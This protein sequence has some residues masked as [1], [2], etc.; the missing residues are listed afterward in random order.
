MKV[1]LDTNVL[2]DCLRRRKLETIRLM[3]IFRD[4]KIECKTSIFTMMELIDTEKDH[5]FFENN[6]KKGKEVSKILR[7]RNNRNLN[8]EDLEHIGEG[9]D[10]LM[11]TYGFIEFVTLI[12]QGGNNSFAICKESNLDADDSI[13]LASALGSGCTILLTSDG[14]FKKE[15]ERL[16]EKINNRPEKEKKVDFV[17]MS[18][19][20]FMKTHKDFVKK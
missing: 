5:F 8:A 6:L 11:E 13:H 17:I 9:I 7:E 4:K 19:E 2:R 12:E 10:N 20:E 18:P 16:V 3:E 14:S 1:Y 15:G